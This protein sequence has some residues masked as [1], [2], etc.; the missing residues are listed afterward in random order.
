M[1]PD[2]AATVGPTWVDIANDLT[3]INDQGLEEHSDAAIHAIL[4]FAQTTSAVNGT[5]KGSTTSSKNLDW[6]GH[7][8]VR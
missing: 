6:K 8:R 1:G 5:D 3:N 4:T 2:H 7:H